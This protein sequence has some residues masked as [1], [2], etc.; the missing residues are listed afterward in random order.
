MTDIGGNEMPGD[1]V[2]HAII[3]CDECGNDS[4]EWHGDLDT[5]EDIYVCSNC[6]KECARY[7]NNQIKKYA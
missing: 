6:G 5:F 7:A 3:T 2:V 4:F 1:D